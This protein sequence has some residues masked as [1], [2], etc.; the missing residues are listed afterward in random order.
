MLSPLPLVGRARELAALER[1]L[2]RE[3]DAP[4]T[5]IVAGEGGVGKSRLV[6]EFAERA[7]RRGWSVAH[8]RAY[9]VE[10]GVPY[11]PFSDAFLPLLQE[12]SPERLTVL[13]RGGEAELSFLF[14]ALASGEHAPL[15]PSVD[16]E[17]A[18]TRLLWNFAEFLRSYAHRHPL[19]V[20]LEDLHWADPSSLHLLHF[21]A[22]QL[23]EQPIL[24]V[25]TYNDDERDSNPQLVQT[26]RSLVSLKVAEVLRLQPLTRDEV[27]ELLCRTFP[28]D[29]SLVAP[30]AERLHEWTRGN[31][32]F[33]EEVLKSLDA[34]G[35]LHDGGAAW[36][37]F[38]PETVGIPAS[39]RDAVVSRLAFLSAEARQVAEAAAVIGT[40]ASFPL[41]REVTGMDEA[42]LLAGLEEL[43]SHRIVVERPRRDEVLYDFSH[44]VVRQ[45][46]YTELGV[47]RTRLMHGSVA[48]AMERHYGTHA[49]A[50]VDELAYHYSR[51]DARH[52]RGKAA[53][54][55]AAAGMRALERRADREAVRYLRRA[56][57]HQ[58]P[59]DDPSEYRS[60]VTAL[61][62][63]HQHLGDYEAAVELWSAALRSLDD[64]DP[65]A[66][67]IRRTLGMA[68]YWCGR[69]GDAH[70]QFDRALAEAEEV[71]DHHEVVRVRIAKAH[72]LH[73]VGQGAEALMT[74]L[75]ALPLAEQLGSAELLARVHRALGLLYVWLG[76]PQ[77]AR[78][79]GA[80]AAKLARQV[81]DLSAEFWALWGLAVLAGM[82]GDTREMERLIGE[83][84]V[85]AER[86]RSPVLRLWTA[87]ME[88][89]L[90]Y[91]KGEWDLGLRV[92]HQA[93]ALARR[94]NQ[95]A[96]LP[97]LLVWTALI[98]IGR[99][100]LEEARVL[101]E[102][103]A[104]AAGADRY[105]AEP[106]D[107]HQVMP[108]IIGR[109]HYL[110]AAG[111]YEEAIAAAETGLEIAEGT[112]YTLWAIHRLLPI[113]AEACLWA[114]QIEKAEKVGRRMR[115]HARRLDHRLGFAWADA[116]DALV[117]WKKGDPA[118]A[119]DMMRQAA[120]AL[121]RIPMIPY[122]A[123]IRRQMAAR[124]RDIGDYEGSVRELR[125]LHD[126]FS[127]LGAEV[128]LEKTRIQIREIGYRPPPRGSGEGL[129][130]LTER[131]MEVARR[132]AQ[133]LSNKAIA[134]E[135]GISPR[136]VS[137]HLSNIYQKLGIGSRAELADLILEHQEVPRD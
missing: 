123:R 131:E 15:H 112:G 48:E 64:G 94:L 115:E 128:E 4:A 110:V 119:V 104:E 21:L 82:S 105:P 69:H 9:A 98:Y 20:V 83:V 78:R 66:T 39:V 10:A 52:L 107:V 54:Y 5:V 42:E 125:A 57:E 35:R 50:H 22:R 126:T 100:Q 75:P 92:G 127:R 18:R 31:P 60:L 43:R 70:E 26:E 108:A 76:P 89:E 137:T 113:L 55:L 72:C 6:A 133:R 44:P 62:R 99:G 130:G 3:G 103:A 85:L 19:A 121:E 84:N 7:R 124:L 118:G 41:L 129:P 122:A 23:G 80:T 67:A 81:G 132:V 45:T 136:T 28:V 13:S 63:A 27:R 51:A 36:V 101:V 97:R 79:H 106:V 38:D 88:V 95:R 114:E 86:A 32:F 37:E 56:L 58:R 17:E 68:H 49:M 47:Q 34:S 1:L 12:L 90:Y 11:A 109:A 87:D 116:C 14:P 120:E 117:R 2:E 33:V 61:A 135:L 46:L 71:G 53:R 59:Q 93:I 96:L 30:F 134:K 73:E 16:P 8:G 102:E 77:Q 24:L 25:G 91:G 65:E 74:L 111:A 40:H 29:A